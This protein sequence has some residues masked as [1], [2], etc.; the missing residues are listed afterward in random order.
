M[1]GRHDRKEMKLKI[2]SRVPVLNSRA[3]EEGRGERARRK[4][5][6]WGGERKKRLRVLDTKEAGLRVQSLYLIVFT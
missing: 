2:R 3:V 1:E 4:G 6:A 5:N